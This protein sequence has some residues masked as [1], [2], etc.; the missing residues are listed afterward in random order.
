MLF[1]KSKTKMRNSYLER[2]NL[3]K[4]VDEKICGSAA[5][6]YIIKLITLMM[7]YIIHKI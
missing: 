3:K 7:I 6:I 4:G 2:K 1:A 5:E